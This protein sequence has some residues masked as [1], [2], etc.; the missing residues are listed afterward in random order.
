MALGLS[1]QKFLT[2]FTRFLKQEMFL[3][4]TNHVIDGH[5]DHMIESAS[6]RLPILSSDQKLS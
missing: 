6:Y 1:F 5:N 2:P 3:G 4:L